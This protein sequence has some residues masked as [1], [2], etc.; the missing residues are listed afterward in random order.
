MICSVK[1][2]VHQ[3]SGS[4]V[5]KKHQAEGNL[6]IHKLYKMYEVLNTPEVGRHCD[7]GHSE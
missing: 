2:K 1:Q 4:Q 7:H 3:N 6:E 5:G